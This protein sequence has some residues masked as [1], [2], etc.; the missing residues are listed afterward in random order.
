M[1]K[2]VLAM[3]TSLDGFI[4][5]VDGELDWIFPNMDAEVRRWII[6]SVGQT[7]TQLL[8]RVNYAQQAE[9][10][11]TSDEEIAAL[12]NAAT[13]IVFSSTLTTLE[14]GNSRLAERDVADEIAELKSLPG[15]D[16]LV[17]GGASFAQYVSGRGLVDEYRLIVYP[18]AL[19]KGLPLFTHPRTL[20]LLASVTFGTGAVAL[21]YEPA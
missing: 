13:K 10:W 14:W 1:R 17:P 20:R 12:I 6:D 5:T 7:D 2:V 3:A 8:G 4:A 18:V 16:I 21:T 11:P 19:G 15:K 9:Y